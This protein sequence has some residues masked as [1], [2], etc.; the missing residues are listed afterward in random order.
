MDKSLIDQFI[1]IQP[2]GTSREGPQ[3]CGEFPASLFS[4]PLKITLNPSYHPQYSVRCLSFQIW[5]SIDKYL[6][7]TPPPT[8]WPFGIWV[9]MNNNIF[10]KLLPKHQQSWKWI[11]RPWTNIKHCPWSQ[12]NPYICEEW[13]FAHSLKPIVFSIS[14]RTD[15]DKKVVKT[16]TWKHA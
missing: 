5:I 7:G 3:S 1:F 10:S 6:L 8:K 11:P 15:S 14:I 13:T 16:R 4:H 12:Q 2:D 9:A